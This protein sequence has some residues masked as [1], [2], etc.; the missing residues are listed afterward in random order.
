MLFRRLIVSALLFFCSVPAVMATQLHM[1]AGAGL[2][3]PIEKLI[4]RFEK[5]TG[6]TVTV[7]YGGS[8]Q[9]LTRFELTLPTVRSWLS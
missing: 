9:I 8:G 1:Y 6:N 7:E 3:P 5:E 2:R 4:S